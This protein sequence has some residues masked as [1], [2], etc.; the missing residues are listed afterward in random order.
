MK[1]MPVVMIMVCAAMTAASAQITYQEPVR[2]WT[3][4]P[5]VENE[6]PEGFYPFISDTAVQILF[7]P[8]AAARS[9]TRFVYGFLNTQ[10][11]YQYDYPMINEATI[12]PSIAA[13]ALLGNAGRKWLV[14][15]ASHPQYSDYRTRGDAV[16]LRNNADSREQRDNA[17][18]FTT[19]VKVSAIGT[20]SAGGYSAGFYAAHLKNTSDTYRSEKDLYASQDNGD[21]TME[22]MSRT[23]ASR[24]GLG[25]ELAWSGPAWNFKNVLHYQNTDFDHASLYTYIRRTNDRYYDYGTGEIISVQR[26]YSTHETGSISQKPNSFMV[27]S[28]FG[29]KTDW[30]VRDDAFF[31]Q[32]RCEYTRGLIQYDYSYGMLDDSKGRI[33][34]VDSTF[35]RM[36]QRAGASGSESGYYWSASASWGYVFRKRMS[37]LFLLSGISAFYRFG[38]VREVNQNSMYNDRSEPANVMLLNRQFG[39]GYVYFPLFIEYPAAKWISIKGGCHCY[40][41]F[42]RD[43]GEYHAPGDMKNTVETTGDN[44]SYYDSVRYYTDYSDHQESVFPEKAFLTGLTLRHPRGFTA[45]ISFNGSLSNPGYWD[46]AL[47]YEF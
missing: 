18:G 17:E 43:R 40:F 11:N 45:R 33:A 34:G 7:N 41:D 15:I 31:A 37:D 12:N 13:T 22:R 36:N 39:R 27:E 25:V 14:T 6:I 8:S 26:E 42:T 21:R 38:E 28:Y 24:L 9:G 20:T 19:M 44:Q 23:G 47:G 32:V 10:G 30:L 29:R 1:R 2:L 4:I 5:G 16:T 3:G 46:V 35:G